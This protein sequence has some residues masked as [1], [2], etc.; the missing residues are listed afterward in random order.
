MRDTVSA[1]ATADTLDSLR[2]EMRRGAIVLAVLAQ[3]HT[4]HYGYSLR[5]TLADKGMPVE[6]GTLYPLVRRLESQGLLTSEWREENR[7][8]KRFYQVSPEGRR[9]YE[10]LLDEWRALGGAM[11]QLTGAGVPAAI[12]PHTDTVTKTR[13]ES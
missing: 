12:V 2:Q 3:L 6:E 4:E 7:R 5:K 1:P 13:R 9:V 10:Q 11:D 8:N